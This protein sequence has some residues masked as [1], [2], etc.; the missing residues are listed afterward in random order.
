MKWIQ[1]IQSMHFSKNRNK[2]LEILQIQNYSIEINRKRIKNLHLKIVPPSGEIKISAPLRMSKE[3]IKTFVISKLDWIKKKKEKFINLPIELKKEFISNEIHYAFGKPYKL[4]ILSNKKTFFYLKDSNLILNLNTND[5]LKK[6][7]TV[8]HNFY[9]NLLMNELDRLV[10][11]WK[12]KM[13]INHFSYSVRLMKNRWGTC[14]PKKRMIWLNLELAK[15][16]IEC[17]EYVLAHEMVHLLESS[18]NKRFYNLMDK[19]LS[20]WKELKIKLNEPL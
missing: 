7:K 10:I 9:K 15:K 4:I 14:Y 1:S 6:K 12:E 8:L 2:E 5:S 11:Q 3:L 20:N 19:Y 13:N 16:P 17:I 18:H